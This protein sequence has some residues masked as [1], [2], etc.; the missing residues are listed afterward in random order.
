MSNHSI[1]NIAL[2]GHS[3]AGKTA[4]S[5][6]MLYSTGA[7]DRLGRVEEGN[8]TSDY[9]KDEI[10]R[11]TSIS[12]T[13]LFSNWG[14]T[15]INIIDTP[16]FSDFGAE[17]RA[18]LRVVDGAVVVVD[19]FTGPEVGTELVWKY[20]QEQHVPRAI[21]LNRLDKD[22]VSFDRTLQ[23]LRDLFG[24]GVVPL[25]FPLGEGANFGKIA[26][27]LSG[28]VY[29]YKTGAPKAQEG[30][31]PA[32]AKDKFAELRR[33]LMEAVAE[34][35]EE[36][37]EVYYATNELSKEQL[38]QGLRKEFAAGNLFPVLCGSAYWPAGVDLLLNFITEA[39]PDPADR[40]AVKGMRPGTTQ[41]ISRSAKDSALTAFVF[42]TVSEQHLGELSFFRVFSGEI[43]AGSEVFNATQKTSEKMGQLYNMNGKTRKNVDHV[44]VGD[45]GAVVKL[46]NTHSSDTLSDARDT[47]ILLGVEVPDPVHR[48]AVTPKA[49]GDE[50]KLSSGLHS[51]HEED[52]S[53]MASFDPEL[54]QT[55]VAG[56]GELQINIILKRLKDKYGVEVETETPGIPYRE[57]IRKA[58]EGQ[59]KHKKQSGGRGQ[60]GD[61]WLRLEPQPRGSQDVLEFVDAIVGGVV[62]GRFIPA[63]EKGIRAAMEEGVISGNRVVDIRATIYDGS[64]HDVD[65]SE[66]AFK[67]AAS[68]GFKRI[69][70]ECNPVILE[71]I[72]DIEVT[73]PEEY[74]GD[75]MGDISSRRGKIQGMDHEGKFQ[76]IKAKVPL[77]ELAT[78][79]INLRSMTSGR[80]LFRMKFSHYEPVP[81]EV[82]D[83]L[84]S[85]YE[86]RRE[87]GS[88]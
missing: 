83:K 67:I 19:G 59:G 55:I 26:D 80:G 16:G 34:S 36:L 28:K 60:Y 72:Y 14:S 75:V 76:I 21:F 32:E 24:T 22:H 39:F 65:S 63:V 74:M 79:S 71:P 1:R 10:E 88:L 49:K 38:V 51:L 11:Q 48:I 5:E 7:I 17:V 68:M 82:Q 15:K 44:G 57:T 40:P 25:Q 46:K 29:T 86:A 78:Y 33:S 2:I 3:G 84:V 56:Q 6:A 9:Q 18:A 12:A 20:A 54:K 42:K 69:F 50:E 8:T 77:A 58:H 73:V 43:K 13:P 31:I 37:L 66:M 70:K 47:I 35:N 87:E 61:V 53:F 27:L 30:E 23:S 4:L 41:E 85:A 45:I 81:H 64:Y 52:P 62:P